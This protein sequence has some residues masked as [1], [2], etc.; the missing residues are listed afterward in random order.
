MDKSY[1]SFV[2]ELIPGE[3]RVDLKRRWSCASRRELSL[4]WLKDSLNRRNLQFQMFGFIACAEELKQAHYERT[5]CL[6]NKILLKRIC[7]LL[8]DIAEL[9]FH[10]EVL[11]SNPL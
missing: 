4:A 9:Q 3:E 2:R 5:A 7:L 8:D 11:Q 10:I 1:W 6:R